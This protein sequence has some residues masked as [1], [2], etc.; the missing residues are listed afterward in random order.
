MRL[1]ELFLIERREMAEWSYVAHRSWRP[2]GA[3][4]HLTDHVLTFKLGHY[5]LVKLGDSPR[6]AYLTQGFRV[7][8][9][10]T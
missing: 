1:R 10:R 8:L 5:P 4:G 3:P 6:F 2:A 7:R 9:A